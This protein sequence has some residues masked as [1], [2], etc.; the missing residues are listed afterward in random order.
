MVTYLSGLF[1]FFIIYLFI[2]FLIAVIQ[3]REE[4]RCLLNFRVQFFNAAIPI[5][6]PIT[7]TDFD[8]C[9]VLSATIDMDTV[10]VS[11]T[12]WPRVTFQF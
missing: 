11:R 2:Y 1:V 7:E 5:I 9:G 12:E 8:V 4:K 6:L 3:P 10:R